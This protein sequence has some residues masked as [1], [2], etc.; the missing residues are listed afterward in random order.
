MYLHINLSQTYYYI[1]KFYLSLVTRKEA[2][3]KIAKSLSITLM[4]CFDNSITQYIN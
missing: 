3:F 1:K 4:Q 2:L